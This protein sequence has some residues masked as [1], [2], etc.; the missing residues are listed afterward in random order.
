MSAT[1]TTLLQDALAT[2]KI[3]EVLTKDQLNQVWALLNAYCENGN[4]ISVSGFSEVLEAQMGITDYIFACLVMDGND[5]QLV[6]SDE[7]NELDENDQEAFTAECMEA[8]YALN[9]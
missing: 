2:R 4:D 3:A 5:Q 6:P 7:Y 9:A 1:T 8:L